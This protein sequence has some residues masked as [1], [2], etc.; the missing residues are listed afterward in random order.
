MDMS[1]GE[2]VPGVL[3][4]ATADERPRPTTQPRALEA[5]AAPMAGKDG[6]RVDPQ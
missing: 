6:C 5:V 3:A 4:A 1:T 2:A